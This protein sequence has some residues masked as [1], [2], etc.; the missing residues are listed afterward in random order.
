MSVRALVFGARGQIGRFLLPRLLAAEIEVHAVTRAAPPVAHAAR[1]HWHRGELFAGG[2]LALP[3]QLVLSLGPL[4]G[5]VAWW[6]RS[7]LRA[8]RVVAFGSTSAATKRDSRDAGERALAARLDAAEQ[9]LQ[10]TCAERGVRC[11]VLRPTLIYGAGLDRN[12]S[13]LVRIA[14]RLRV[15]PL[16]RDATGLRQPVHA[17]DLA[18]A[19]FV[20]ARA[21]GVL[22]P[23]YDLPGGEA[24]AYREMVRRVLACLD[25][26]RR[27]LPMPAS[28][29]RAAA[30]LAQRF[31][32]MDENTGAILTRMREDLVFDVA[33]A[34]R[35][36]DFR[37]RAFEPRAEM[38]VSSETT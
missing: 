9:A 7:A 27:I 32:A 35:D 20:A 25:P 5:F 26:P 4:D 24:L 12:L 21:C 10:A 15:L 13:R 11:T 31:G 33:P 22:Q 34:R 6:Q 8:E 29:C 2:D 28:V 30:T 18:Q 38:F 1:L 19:A 37:P 16:P 3:V 36:L 17:D 14:Q 23:R